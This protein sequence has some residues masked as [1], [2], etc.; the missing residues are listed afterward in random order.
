MDNR[1]R[2][3]GF[4]LAFVFCAAT[5]ALTQGNGQLIDA[6]KKG[7]VTAARAAIAGGANVGEKGD[8]GL[9]PLMWAALYGHTPVIEALLSSGAPVNDTDSEGATALAYARLGRQADAMRVLESRGGVLGK[10]EVPATSFDGALKTYMWTMSRRSDIFDYVNSRAKEEKAT[11][12]AVL[13]ANWS[14]PLDAPADFRG[15]WQFD[16]GASQYGRLPKP[17]TVNFTITQAANE[18]VTDITVDGKQQVS[19]Y[20][21]DG[22][23]SV[24]AMGTNA[25]TLAKARWDGAKLVISSTLEFEQVERAALEEIWSLS[26]DRSVLTV[27]RHV[28]KPTESRLRQVI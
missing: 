14:A 7:D 24:N 18:L 16:Q 23:V 6:A 17:K 27:E 11:A 8:A 3:W 5:L 22:A 1:M 15:R 10:I 2:V 12:D 21:L 19:T 9:S 20:T 4:G 26:A 25:R 13:E 28:T